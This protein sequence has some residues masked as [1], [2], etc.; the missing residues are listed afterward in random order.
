MWKRRA[1]SVTVR[2]CRGGLPLASAVVHLSVADVVIALV[3]TLAGAVVQGSIGFGMNLVAVPVLAIVEPAALPT[4]AVLLGV[5][6]SVTMVRHERHAIDRGAVGWILVGRVPGTIV[7]AVIVVLVATSTLSII[8]GAVVLASV[9]MSVVG[10]RIAVTP[11]S[12]VAA[13]VESGVMGT[14]AGIG[15]PPLALLFQHHEGPVMR[16]TLAASFFFGTLVSFATLA[17]AGEVHANQVGLAL[18][19]TPAVLVGFLTARRLHGTLDRG[20]LRPAVLGFGT[21]SAIVAILN[22]LR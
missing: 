18:A 1:P 20:W 13:G 3:A 15:G 4:V 16:A 7:G 12:C 6:M 19:L 21:V 2:K 5:P 9:V 17:I 10:R 22:G 14:A 11:R 8:V